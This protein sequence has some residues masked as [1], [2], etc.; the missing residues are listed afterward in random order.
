MNTVVL[1]TWEVWI[2]MIN[3]DGPVLLHHKRG[4]LLRAAMLTPI[5]QVLGTMMVNKNNA[6]WHSLVEAMITLGESKQ[7]ALELVQIARII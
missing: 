7:E 3:A 5:N 2:L 1:N 6:M 4:G